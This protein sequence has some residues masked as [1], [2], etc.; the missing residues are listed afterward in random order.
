[1]HNEVKKN[2]S[3]KEHEKILI[4]E[5]RRKTIIEAAEKLFLTKGYDNTTMQDVAEK[6]GYSKGTLYNTFETREL[7]DALYLSIATKAYELFLNLLK[8][9]LEKVDPGIQQVKEVGL[10]YYDFI[11]EYPAYANIFHDIAQKVPNLDSKNKVDLDMIE[12]A[13][14]QKSEEFGEYFVK[15]LG[16]AIQ[17]KQIRSDK[18][19][20][21]IGF[22]LSN[23][24]NGMMKE[25]MQHENDL[26]KFSID[27]DELVEFTFEIIAEGLKPRE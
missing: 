21:L 26:K 24:T 17:S 23:L 6:A 12:K 1:M 7:K 14:L 13:Y 2:M 5:H 20:I 16:K 19:P 25:L 4:E 8:K 27:P 11:R 22:M 3:G 18:P 10:V 9:R 15:I